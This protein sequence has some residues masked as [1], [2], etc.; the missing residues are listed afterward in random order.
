MSTVVVIAGYGPGISHSVAKRLGKGH[1][2]ALISRTASKVKGAAEA[3][4]QEGIHT[5]G[6]A[7]DLG[8]PKAIEDTLKHIQKIMGSVS[9]LFWNGGGLFKPLLQ[10]SIED[11]N[12]NMSIN[13]VSLV[14]AVQT[15]QA[16]LEHNKGSVLVTGGGFGADNQGVNGYVVSLGVGTAGVNKA[17]EH[18]T[19]GILHEEMKPK[20]VFVGAVVVTAMVK[21]TAWD[22]G[23]ATLEAD[24]VAETFDNLLQAR[25]EPFAFVG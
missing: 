8:N 24:K 12:V 4:T 17:A 22:S 13:V 25:S 23:S 1:K 5:E 10:S 9:L 2:V 18:K 16:D 14:H 21:G 19:V 7:A 6:F 11:L 3:L 15:V 20:G